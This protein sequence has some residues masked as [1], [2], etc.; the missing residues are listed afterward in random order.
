M[1]WGKGATTVGGNGN[2]MRNCDKDGNV[3]DYSDALF[4]VVRA[5]MKEE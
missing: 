4:M 5:V 3:Q 2:G 1:I